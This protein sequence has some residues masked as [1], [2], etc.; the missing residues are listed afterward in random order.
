M[1]TITFIRSVIENI[2]ETQSLMLIII[3]LVLFSYISLFS[4]HPSRK[5]DATWAMTVPIIGVFCCIVSSFSDEIFLELN[6]DGIYTIF[7]SSLGAEL[8][9]GTFVFFL[10]SDWEYSNPVWPMN[11]GIALTL[12]L[13]AMMLAYS[14][15]MITSDFL[16]TVNS[17][18]VTFDL[19]LEFLTI[20]IIIVPM[21]YLTRIGH[22]LINFPSASIL[23]RIK[24]MISPFVAGGILISITISIAYIFIVYTEN[25]N[26]LLLA[27]MGGLVTSLA[28]GSWVTRNDWILVFALVGVF[29]F[30]C[31][32]M[33]G[34]LPISQTISIAISAEL[35][36]ALTPV[37][38]LEH[39]KR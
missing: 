25:V 32:L 13:S 33:L 11:I 5:N 24:A 4:F 26:T 15:G 28:L 23:T 37:I 22:L 35:V 21:I 17:Q 30:I 7:F 1:E 27:L 36:G 6:H 20:P 39:V 14:R 10:L 31:I 8:I 3:I 34:M 19:G 18:N 16:N 29:I 2:D 9:V 12:L 38:M